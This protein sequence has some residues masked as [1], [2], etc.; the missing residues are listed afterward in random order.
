MPVTLAAMSTLESW[1]EEAATALNLPADTIDTALRNALLD[2]T[3][4]A[5]HGVARIAGPLTTYLIGVAVGAGM[6]RDE[7]VKTVGDLAAAHAA[8]AQDEESH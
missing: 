4:D 8:A 7:A 2:V 5:A 1:T 6:S 3:R